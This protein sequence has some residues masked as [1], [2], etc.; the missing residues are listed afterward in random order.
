MLRFKMVQ[1]LTQHHKE[2]QRNVLYGLRV[3]ENNLEALQL[4]KGEQL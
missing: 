3:F 4:E 2:F 1:N